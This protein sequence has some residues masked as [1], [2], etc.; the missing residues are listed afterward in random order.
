MDTLLHDSTVKTA[1]TDVRPEPSHTARAGNGHAA[2]DS[3]PPYPPLPPG[4]I[5]ATP[6][7]LQALWH[8]EA[9]YPYR[10][11][12]YLYDPDTTTDPYY[13]RLGVRFMSGVM[14]DNL[15]QSLLSAPQCMKSF[16]AHQGD[17]WHAAYDV[18]ILHLPMHVVTN[19]RYAESRRLSPDI[20]VWDFP[21]PYAAE[22]AKPSYDFGRNGALQWVMELVS[23]SDRETRDR[24]WIVKRQV[25][26]R[27][28]I[29]EYWLW[30][31]EL[32]PA[33]WV[34]TLDPVPALAPDPYRLGDADPYPRRPPEADGSLYSAVLQT[35]LRLAERQGRTLLQCWSS[36]LQ[37]WFDMHTPGRVEGREATQREN[38]LH[39]V[40]GMPLADDR[41][42]ALVRTRIG[43]MEQLPELPALL[44]AL[45]DP[46]AVAVT[47]LLDLEIGTD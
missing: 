14:D 17:R 35:R 46:D 13:D 29:R 38:L 25:Y 27:L 32:D 18:A 15:Q 20:S 4:Y 7:Q 31:F 42:Q 30:D 12:R 43:Q 33:L 10:P 47:T 34:L 24:D 41:L 36:R 11:E 39:L 3:R 37:D 23:H 22:G 8:Y 2:P 1:L 21:P 5:P 40:D 44:R 19:T 28:H 45:Q 16:L 26:A 6:E 9:D